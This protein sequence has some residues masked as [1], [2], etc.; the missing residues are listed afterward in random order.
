[1]KRNKS[2]LICICA[3]KYVDGR[4]YEN[5]IA[6]IMFLF[7]TPYGPIW[8]LAFIQ[9]TFSVISDIGDR[10]RISYAGPVSRICTISYVILVIYYFV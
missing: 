9:R 2:N 7:P 1:M 8:V 6:L 4:I 3:Y 10:F 5:Q